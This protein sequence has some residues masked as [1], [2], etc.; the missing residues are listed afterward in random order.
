MRIGWVRVV[1]IGLRW[2]VWLLLPWLGVLLAGC[3]MG[4][5]GAGDKGEE[6][7]SDRVQ[8]PADIIQSGKTW[9]LVDI[10]TDT[11]SVMQGEKT[12]ERFDN[13]AIGR[14]GAAADRV[15]GDRRTPLGVFRIGWVNGQSRFRLFFGFDYPTPEHA[16]RGLAAGIISDRE[17]GRIRAAHAAG[18]IPPQNTR[19]GGQIGIHGLGRGDPGIHRDFNWTEGCIALTNNQIDRLAKWLDLGTPVVVR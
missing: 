15:R 19:L 10:E 3:S 5:F 17:L 12:I 14:G 9:V 1:G 2:K 13:I 6:G 7:E 16:E 8:I 4:W 11:L 18:R